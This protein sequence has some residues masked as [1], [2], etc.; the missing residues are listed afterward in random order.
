[1]AWKKWEKA[2]ENY[3]FGYSHWQ[4]SIACPSFSCIPQAVVSAVEG[5]LLPPYLDI[6]RGYLPNLIVPTPGGHF[7]GFQNL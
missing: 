3:G 7:D 5:G 2:E 6:V 4:Y 1:M